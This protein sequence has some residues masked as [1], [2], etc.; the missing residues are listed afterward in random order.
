M[1]VGGIIVILN[2][3]LGIS[4]RHWKIEGMGII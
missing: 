4:E 3:I 2:L 1:D